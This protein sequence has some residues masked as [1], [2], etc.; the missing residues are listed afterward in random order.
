MLFTRNFLLLETIPGKYE[1]DFQNNLKNPVGLLYFLNK[2]LLPAYL[3]I[4]NAESRFTIDTS[5]KVNFAIRHISAGIYNKIL[6]KNVKLLLESRDEVLERVIETFDYVPDVESFRITNVD[7]DGN[8]F[9]H[10]MELHL[11]IHHSELR[12]L[13]A[14]YI[15][16][17][18]HE[19]EDVIVGIHDSVDEFIGDIT[20]NGNYADHLEL[21][22]IS[23]IYN[24]DIVVHRNGED[25]TGVTHINPSGLAVYHI[26]YTGNHYMNMQPINE[27]NEIILNQESLIPEETSKD[28]IHSAQ[29]P[30]LETYPDSNNMSYLIGLATLIFMSGSHL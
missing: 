2:K 25:S 6:E 3:K 30:N 9:Y 27:Q 21:L 29:Y 16:S 8:C 17:H 24:I 15:I 5:N 26:F 4:E 19:F 11:G 13:A 12:T 1:A 18:I 28:E 22:A 20:T 7:S 23:R 14:E 10:A